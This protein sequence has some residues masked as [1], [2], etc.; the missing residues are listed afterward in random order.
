MRSATN[1]GS[2]SWRYKNAYGTGEWGGD[3]NQGERER[4]RE[5]EREVLV[6]R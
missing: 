2:I 6:G 3:G 5:R 4:E 1:D